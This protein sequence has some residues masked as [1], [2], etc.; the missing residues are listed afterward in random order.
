MNKVTLE[1]DRNT[2]TVTVF[3][4]NK[5][6]SKRTMERTPFGAQGTEPGDVEDDLDPDIDPRLL[7]EIQSLMS[8]GTAIMR[9][10]DLNLE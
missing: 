1:V 2:A 9:Y 4:G 8:N 5:T 7:D 6:L 10:L 3:D